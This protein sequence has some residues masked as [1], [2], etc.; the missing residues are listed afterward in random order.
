M[1]KG[2]LTLKIPPEDHNMCSLEESVFFVFLLSMYVLRTPMLQTLGSEICSSLLVTLCNNIHGLISDDFILR[3]PSC[4]KNPQY[5]H[6][7]FLLYIESAISQCLQL[8]ILYI[9]PNIYISGFTFMDN[10][11]LAVL[12]AI[13]PTT[14]R[15]WV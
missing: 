15:K 4:T 12:D 1:A 6:Q 11:C 9:P 5:T 8:T 7:L 3:S 10:G 14:L 2:Y 13:G